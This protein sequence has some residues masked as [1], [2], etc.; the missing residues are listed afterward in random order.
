MSISADSRY[1]LGEI[2]TMLLPGGG[3]NIAVFA[4]PLS[5]DPIQITYY[6]SV[7]GDRFD[8]LAMRYYGDPT[9]WWVIADMNPT[10]Q[11][12]ADIT[13]GT[14]LRVPVYSGMDVNTSNSVTRLAANQADSGITRG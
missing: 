3:A 12:P 1:S 8:A 6:S 5:T 9:K 2:D 4:G 7:V 11:W 13:P 14:L 10:I